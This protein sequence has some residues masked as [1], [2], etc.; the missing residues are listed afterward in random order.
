MAKGCAQQSIIPH[1]SLSQT[2]TKSQNTQLS[3]VS[4]CAFAL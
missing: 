4:L 2:A 3:R 1:V